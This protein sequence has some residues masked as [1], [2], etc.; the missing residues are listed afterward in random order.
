M[1]KYLP[2]LFVLLFLISISGCVE[3][4]SSLTELPYASF[5]DLPEDYTPEQALEDGYLVITQEKGEDDR[6]W[7]SSMAARKPGMRFW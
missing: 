4:Q 2:L 7:R 1:K 5:E 3:E 6:P